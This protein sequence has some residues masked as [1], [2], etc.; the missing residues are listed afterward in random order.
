MLSHNSAVLRALLLLHIHR[1]TGI[2]D[3]NLVR[4]NRQTCPL[5]MTGETC[6]TN[7]VINWR[8]ENFNSNEIKTYQMLISGAVAMC[9][10]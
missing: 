5:A 7:D 2:P 10:R 1:A 9:K 8:D 6:S 4:N 3:T